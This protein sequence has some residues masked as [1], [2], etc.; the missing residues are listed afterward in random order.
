METTFQLSSPSLGPNPEVFYLKE[1][2]QWTVFLSEITS[3]AG[4]IMIYTTLG[5]LLGRAQP[6]AQ[7]EYA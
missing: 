2:C 3:S 7:L 1:P 4:K 5:Y 6:E